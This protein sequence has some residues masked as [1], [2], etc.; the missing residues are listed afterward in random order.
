M[1]QGLLDFLQS[2]SNMVS[3]N[4]AG[5]V[6]LLGMGLNKIGVPVG[7]APIGGTEWMKRQGLMRDVQQG[8]ARVLGETAGLLG[9][10]MVTQ[11]APQIAKG[12]L[13]AEAN[14]AKPA[15][16]RK[17]SGMFIGPSAKTWDEAAAKKAQTLAA[18]GTDPR[19]IWAETGTFKGPDGKWRQ[20]IDDSAAKL[21]NAPVNKS[22][23]QFAN[24]FEIAKYGRRG[25]EPSKMKAKDFKEYQNWRSGIEAEYN[26]TNATMRPLDGIFLHD[27][28]ASSY[29]DVYGT[30][31]AYWDKS[32]GKSGSYGQGKI[33]FGDASNPEGAKGLFAH[34]LQ[35]AIQNREGFARG[36]SP[37]FAAMPE[38]E[39]INKQL[40]WV[41]KEIDSIKEMQFS[42]GVK[43]ELVK[44]QLHRLDS[45]YKGLLNDRANINH[46]DTYRRLAGEAEARATQA[47]VPLNAAQRRGLF[48]LDSYDVPLDQLIIRGQ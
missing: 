31:S 23:E 19:Q 45:M 29:P 4:I 28:A 20:E 48:P 2:A 35:H 12:L 11:F 26:K 18:K 16:L 13:Q 42:Q 27:K 1:N 10:A 33:S 21:V 43:P 6:D 5:P 41:S 25:A 37:D 14:A 46:F 34:E 17:E 38:V 39:A 9:P 3:S 30:T 15:V 24:E 36:G 8:P 47:R 44:D 22:W 40:S 7:N 32:M